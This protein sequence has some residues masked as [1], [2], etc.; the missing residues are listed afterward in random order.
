MANS[1]IGIVHSF[2]RDSKLINGNG[3]LIN[4]D[5]KFS[6]CDSS[7]SNGNSHSLTGITHSF[8]G[9]LLYNAVYGATLV[10]YAFLGCAPHFYLKQLFIWSG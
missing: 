10:G 9:P 7:F 2:D 4:D 5:N 3:K 1:L 6:N 8:E